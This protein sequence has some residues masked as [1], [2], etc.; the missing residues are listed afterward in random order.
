MLALIGAAPASSL[1]GAADATMQQSPDA[2][3]SSGNAVRLEAALREMDRL[4]ARLQT[5]EDKASRARLLA[6]YRGALAEGMSSLPRAANPDIGGAGD[7]AEQVRL[8]KRQQRRLQGLIQ[9]LWTY[10]RL[11]GA[12]AP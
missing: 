6:D 2:V 1:A 4:R 5:T 7:P 12:D 9:H 11:S 3:H 8:L 10:I